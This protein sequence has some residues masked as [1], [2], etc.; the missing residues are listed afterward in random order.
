VESTEAAKAR[1]KTIV[2]DRSQTQWAVL[3]LESLISEDHPARTIW[4]L[5]GRFDLSRFEEDQKT[6]EGEAGR[7]CW[8]ARLLVSVWVYSY[9]AGVASG[10]AI[11]RMLS[12]EPGLRWLTA[13]QKINHHTLT[14]FRVGHKE[15]L[16]GLFAQFLALLETAGLV[17]LSTLLHDGTK[18]R[19]VA[20]KRSFHRRRT[21]EKR[22]REARKV[23]RK[24]E[25]RAEA[26]GEA[27]DEKRRAAQ[28][29]AAQQALR[30][31]EA[32]ME[33]LKRLEAEA[34]PN[35]RD[36][37]RVSDSEAEARNMKHPDGGW[38]PSYNV[39]VSTEAQS[40]MIVG[41]D[42]T[43][44]ANDTHQ[45]MPALEKVKE[46]CG[47]VPERIIADNGYATRSNVEQTSQQNI[48]L[49]A[50]WKENA[51]RE[52]GACKRNGIVAEFAPSAF[53]PQRGGKKLT[54]PAGKTLLLVQ[55]RTH[56][57]VLRNVFEA[58][59]GD[60]A[61]C[62]FRKPCCGADRSRRRVD[63]VVETPAMKQYLARMQRPE[64][65]KLY[66]KRSEIAEFPHLWTKAV[67][68]WRR[69]SVRGVVKA[70]I[71]ALWVA[72]S[73][74]LAQWMRVRQTVSAA[75]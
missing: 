18:V 51:S 64:V 28:A 30:R 33:K 60:C 57:G 43:T 73:Y 62:R 17:D 27:M 54:C 7:P 34:A 37:L 11:E 24:L 5:S 55:Q 42:V 13:D 12:H 36:K 39:Q 72:L 47:V 31:A 50:P 9:T 52:A 21:L 32:A 58:R 8:P 29:R 1:I 41:I 3:D 19:A 75:A 71:E 66:R 53:R 15:A 49:I 14:D 26:E 10:R 46:N 23:V 65:R 56:H 48:E 61:H 68:K 6:R 70:G 25:A 69:F 74:N 63:R 4:E 40:R 59:P 44:A 38:A 16:E 2:V 20:G 22:V 45:L 67:K 35:E